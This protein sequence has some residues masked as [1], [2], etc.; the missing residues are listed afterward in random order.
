MLKTPI[1]QI[2]CLEKAQKMG[3]SHKNFLE[4]NHPA[5]LGYLHDYG[6]PHGVFQWAS[7]CLMVPWGIIHIDTLW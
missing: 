7:P 3:V 6:N 1:S 2:R 4:I 5:N